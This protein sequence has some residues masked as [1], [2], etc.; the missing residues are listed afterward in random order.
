MYSK[1]L[2]RY[3][4]L[5]MGV[6][7][8]VGGGVMCLYGILVLYVSAPNSRDFSDLEP[9]HELAF[10]LAQQE[11]IYVLAALGVA[12]FIWE[13]WKVGFFPKDERLLY[14]KER[15]KRREL[16]EKKEVWDKPRQDEDSDPYEELYEDLN[17][18]T[19]KLTLA[20]TRFNQSGSPSVIGLVLNKSAR[21]PYRDIVIKIE[22]YDGER[23]HID[24]TVATKKELGIKSSWE[25]EV[26]PAP[27]Y[28]NRVQYYKVT[29][30][31][32]EEV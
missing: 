2:R 11:L 25:F 31:E 16:A 21:K 20:R 32:A 30:I 8:I 17:E 29:D 6:V 22:F 1:L 23:K 26:F 14:Q 3:G 13:V 15:D 24:T 27:E 19:E 28:S 5:F 9:V 4:F 10:W 7:T 12:G 18:E